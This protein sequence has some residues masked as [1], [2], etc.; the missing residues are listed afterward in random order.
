M[1]RLTL[2]AHIVTLAML[3]M[4]GSLMI[5]LVFGIWLVMLCGTF[6]NISRP[7]QPGAVLSSWVL[8]EDKHR[9]YG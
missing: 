4:S 5:G 2:Q 9:G 3:L 6:T 8:G 7:A 1:P